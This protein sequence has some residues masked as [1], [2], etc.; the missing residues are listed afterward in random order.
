LPACHRYPQYWP[1]R[2]NRAGADCRRADKTGILRLPEAYESGYL[3]RTTGD[4]IALSPPLIIT[5]AEI[6]ELVEGIRKVL[7][8]NA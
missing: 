3:I 6:D 5:K 4:I 7:I 1:D 2:C 8:A